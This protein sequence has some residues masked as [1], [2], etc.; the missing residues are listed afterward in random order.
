MTS[1][2]PYWGK[3][4]SVTEA[5]RLIDK[6]RQHSPHATRAAWDEQTFSHAG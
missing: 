3:C 2:G 4:D 1:R 6:N 5:E